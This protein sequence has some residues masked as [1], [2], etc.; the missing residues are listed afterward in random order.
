[1]LRVTKGISLKRAAKT[2]NESQ[3]EAALAQRT[4]MTISVNPLNALR[5]IE[6]LPTATIAEDECQGIPC[7]KISSTDNRFGFILW[8]SKA[9]F[10]VCRQI[11]LQDG[12]ILFDTQF[13]YKKWNGALVPA[14]T[15]TTKPSNGIRVEQTYSGQAR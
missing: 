9:D 14:R 1:V 4:R 15:V 7:H 13:E 2:A 8:V 5:R 11:V 6:S 12:S 3:A 10:C